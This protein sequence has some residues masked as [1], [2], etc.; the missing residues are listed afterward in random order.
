[1]TSD[2]EMQNHGDDLLEDFFA[3]ARAAPPAPVPDAL[4]ARVLQDADALQ[5]RKAARPSAKGWLPARLGAFFGAGAWGRQMAGLTAAALAGVWLGF[6]QPTGFGMAGI[7]EDDL[8]E[9]IELF[10][11]SIDVWAQELG[12]EILA[13]DEQ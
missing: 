3:A 9:T 4:L 6:M 8:I 7:P 13:E 12:V 5:P 1:M 11:N 10:P 2:K